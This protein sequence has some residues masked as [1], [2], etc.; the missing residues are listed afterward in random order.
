MIKYIQLIKNNRKKLL[1]I[2]LLINILSVIGIFKLEFN[3]DFDIFK[4][5]DSKHLEVY[6]EMEDIFPSKEQTILLIESDSLD[7]DFQEVN[8][9]LEENDVKYFVSPLDILTL[10]NLEEYDSEEEAIK[11]LKGLSPITY[12]DNKIYGTYNFDVKNIKSLNRIEDILKEKQITYFMSGNVFMASEILKLL[13]SILI[14]IPPLALFFILLIFRTQLSSFKATIMSILPA[15][16]ASLWVL[17][18]IGW[19]GGEVS[20]ITVLAPIFAIVIGSADGLHFISHMEEEFRHNKSNVERL[21]HTLS[22]VGIPLIITTA[23]SVIGFLGLLLID[24]EAIRDLAIFASIGVFFAGIITWYILPIILTGDIKLKY[25]DRKYIGIY[26]KE[27]WGMKSIVIV[28]ILLVLSFIFIP[29]I[30]TEFNQLMFFRDYTSIAKNNNKIIELKQSKHEVIFDV[31][32]E[33][34]IKNIIDFII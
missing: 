11:Q 29:N 1:I 9:I 15:G 30:K 20:V 5:D 25:K 32:K 33:K 2:L 27:L 31:E 17:G 10:L 14:F 22:I 21:H 16:L 24:T 12:K 19:F 7:E 23:T 18:I 6:N 8:K 3:V 4:I 26:L 13:L 34:A 28:A